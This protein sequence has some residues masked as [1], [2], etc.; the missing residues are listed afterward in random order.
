MIKFEQLNIN[1]KNLETDTIKD[2]KLQETSTMNLMKCALGVTKEETINCKENTKKEIITVLN[3]RLVLPL[4]IPIIAL[5]SSFLLIKVQS[6]KNIF[7][8]KY[9]V[10]LYSLP[11]IIICR[12]DNS[13]YW[14][15]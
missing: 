13:F 3:R 2:P 12:I 8:N 11:N 14:N 7:L 9:S 4:Y 15:L 6:R 10:F 1:L 5:F